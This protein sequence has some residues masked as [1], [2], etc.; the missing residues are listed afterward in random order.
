MKNNYI[1]NLPITNLYKQRSFN[2]KIDT[3]L[4]YGDSYKILKKYRGWNKVRIK[5]DGYIGYI[6]T[7][8][9][10]VNIIKAGTILNKGFLTFIWVI[11]A[12]DINIA[13]PEEPI[14]TTWS[15]LD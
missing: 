8:K 13:I 2:S 12:A 7:I 5:K 1:N 14:I 15:S 4:L 3:Q 10:I 6:K 11:N 9:L